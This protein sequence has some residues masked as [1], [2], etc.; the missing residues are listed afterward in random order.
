M[1]PLIK[2]LSDTTF[3]VSKNRCKTVM[4]H[5]N[6]IVVCRLLNVDRYVKNGYYTCPTTGKKLKGGIESFNSAQERRNEK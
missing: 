6:P 2:Q 4:T 1:K 3:Q 5:R